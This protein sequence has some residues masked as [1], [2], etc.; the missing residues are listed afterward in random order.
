MKTST[1]AH[2]LLCDAGLFPMLP[3]PPPSEPPAV[4]LRRAVARVAGIQTLGRRPAA[5]LPV[6]AA[7]AAYVD[8]D[9]SDTPRFLMHTASGNVFIPAGEFML[10]LWFSTE[11]LQ[12]LKVS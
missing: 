3:P 10:L 4:P 6:S 11:V 2:V 9:S 5:Q 8:S 7:A 1:Y 12:N